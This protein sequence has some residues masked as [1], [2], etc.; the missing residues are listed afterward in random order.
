MSCLSVSHVGLYILASTH[1]PTYAVL[2]LIE[3]D[4]PT[5]V[6]RYKGYTTL[7]LTQEKHYKQHCTATAK[8][9]IC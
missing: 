8:G 4:I 3:I 6:Q 5:A 7:L 1:Q 2:L 9:S